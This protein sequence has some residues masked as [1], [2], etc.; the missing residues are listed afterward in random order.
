MVGPPIDF[1]LLGRLNATVYVDD[2]FDCVFACLLRQ[3]NCKSVNFVRGTPEDD[4]K[5][6]CELNDETRNTMPTC[7]SEKPGY[8]YYGPP[9]VNINCE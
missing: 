6:T 1:A 8:T 7:L 5:N 3:P 9:S 4:N 2:H